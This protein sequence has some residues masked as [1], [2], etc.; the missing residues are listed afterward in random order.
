V[1]VGANIE[2]RI[3]LGY[4]GRKH[5]Q[6]LFFLDRENQRIALETSGAKLNEVYQ[7]KT[8]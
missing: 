7:V 8:A 6:D 5:V 4:Q 3:V 1:A 2:I